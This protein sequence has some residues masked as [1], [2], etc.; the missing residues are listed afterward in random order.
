MSL[1]RLLSGD[2]VTVSPYVGETANG[3][4][5]GEPVTVDCR[6]NYERKLVRDTTGDEVV[7]ESTVYSL[8]EH[9]AGRTVDLFPPESL[10]VHEGRESRV[11]G[12]SP[13]RGMGG[14]LLVE[15]TT[16]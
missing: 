7:S 6:V 2:T 15:I 14:P 10:I 8:P 3:P 1:R 16:T 4:A 5:Y 12:L 13:H 11:I 9:T